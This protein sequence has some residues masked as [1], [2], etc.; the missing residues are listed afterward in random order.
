MT[1][2]LRNGKRTI[3]QEVRS[4]KIRNPRRLGAL[5]KLASEHHVLISVSI[6]GVTGRYTSAI[7]KVSDTD[8][9]LLLDELQPAIGN[10]ELLRT[11]QL[12]VQL[13]LNGVFMSFSAP[14]T[15]V[16]SE[17]GIAFY[18]LPFPKILDYWQ[19]RAAFRAR[20]MESVTV[21]II[22]DDQEQFS[23]T[24]FDISTQGI[25]L[26]VPD[27]MEFSFETGNVFPSCRFELPGE[28]AIDC[29]LALRFISRSRIT[30]TYRLGCQFVNLNRKD[31]RNIARFV[32]T[33]ERT[34]RSRMVETIR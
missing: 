4:E 9:Y 15:D 5:L 8:Q 6:A 14:V 17:S 26:T 18:R 12:K 30:R 3:E 31:Q 22:S 28:E 16:G 32:A 13:R 1:L 7:I 34:R 19:R 25:A 2:P 27:T 24:I 11:R 29:S 21:R 20:V 33:I 10:Q 23:G